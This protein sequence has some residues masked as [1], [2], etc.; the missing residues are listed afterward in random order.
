[1]TQVAQEEFDEWT[2][3]A[4]HGREAQRRILSNDWATDLHQEIVF[5]R[6]SMQLRWKRKERGDDDQFCCAPAFFN[7]YLLR[8]TLDFWH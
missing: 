2:R 3:E 8:G 7:G 6:I 4:V 5:R 1:V